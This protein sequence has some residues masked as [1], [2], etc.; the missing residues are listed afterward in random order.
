MELVDF[1]LV[2][3]ISLVRFFV[4]NVLLELVM[5]CINDIVENTCILGDFGKSSY[6]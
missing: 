1:S 5:F 6:Y 4:F 2:R 3:R